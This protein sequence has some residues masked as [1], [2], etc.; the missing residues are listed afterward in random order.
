VYDASFLL[1]VPLIATVVMLTSHLLDS[2][3]AL[4]SKSHSGWDFF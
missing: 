2:I 4:N 1:F 3:P